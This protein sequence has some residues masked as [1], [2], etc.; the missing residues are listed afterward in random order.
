[1]IG[2]SY[3]YDGRVKL[4]I[5]IFGLV[6]CC[7]FTTVKKSPAQETDYQFWTD[8]N[9]SYQLSQKVFLVGDVGLRGFI[10]DVDWNQVY[11]RPGVRYRFNKTVNVAGSL[12]SFNTFNLDDYNLSEFRVTADVNVKWPDMGVIDFTYRGRIENR[13]FFRQEG[14]NENNFRGRLL[15]SINTKRF[16]AFSQKRS[17]YFKAQVEPFYTFGVESQDEVFIN[18][19]RV[20]AIFGHY[21]SQKFGYDIQYIWQQTRISAEDPL[22]VS[23]NILRIRFY[24]RIPRKQ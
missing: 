13:T 5:L 14:S 9:Y 24:H 23:Q 3:I 15:I 18:Q 7:L 10:S 12:A 22:Q 8:Y 1:M 4:R 2:N 17:I 11:I 6:T 16:N 21:I 20:Y 19:T